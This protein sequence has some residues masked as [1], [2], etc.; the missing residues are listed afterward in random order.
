MAD[1]HLTDPCKDA[2]YSSVVS[3]RTMRMAL[4]VSEL[5]GL[6][7]M[8]GDIGNAY[9]EAHTK[10]KACIIAGP[11]VG[12]LEGH[13]LIINKALYSLRTSGAR[14]HK[15]LSD[16]LRDM[17]FKPCKADPDLWLQE[18]ADHYEY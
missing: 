11:D 9:L 4:V 15:K 12:E 13:T 17:G 14:F 18:Q 7:V 2:A 8:V 5:N 6:K 16:T 10:E 1:G 3:L